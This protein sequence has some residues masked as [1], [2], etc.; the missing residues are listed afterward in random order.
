MDHDPLNLLLYAYNTAIC[1][2]F[3]K[4]LQLHSMQHTKSLYKISS[5][6]ITVDQHTPNKT[7]QVSTECKKCQQEHYF[8]QQLQNHNTQQQHFSDLC[9]KEM[10]S[11]LRHKTNDEENPST[12]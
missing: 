9:L 11:D 3:I 4:I 7:M 1:I 8:S 6:H 5:L 10:K 2:V 12:L